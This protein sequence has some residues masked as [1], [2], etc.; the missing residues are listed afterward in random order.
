MGVYVPNMEIPSGCPFCWL[1]N[2]ERNSFL[3]CNAV[4][5]KNR[6]VLTDKEYA[7]SPAVSRPDWCPLIPVSTPH[8]RLGDLDRLEQMFADI[9]NAPYSGFDGEEPLYSA[10]NAAQ[11]IRLTSTVIPAETEG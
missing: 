10:E 2:W 5:G 4:I 1:S 7:D 8:G 3:G 6:A 11:I 9:D